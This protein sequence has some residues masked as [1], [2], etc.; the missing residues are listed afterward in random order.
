MAYSIVQPPFPTLA[1]HEMSRRDLDTY[2][3]WFR[4]VMPE[5]IAVLEAAVRDSSP[6]WRADGSPDSLALLGEWF[7]GQ[8][9]T[10]AMTKEEADEITS[11]LTFPIDVPGEELTQRTFSLA[12]DVGLYFGHVVATNLAGTRWV[13]SFKNRREIDYGQPVLAGFGLKQLNPVRIAVILAYAIA[14]K[15]QGGG[16]LREL[17]DVWADMKQP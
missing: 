16:R 11:R 2:G 15:D 1:F 7:A 12:M 5:R 13:T 17:Y 9:E 8:V 6:S 14:S 3:A 4:Q 10:R